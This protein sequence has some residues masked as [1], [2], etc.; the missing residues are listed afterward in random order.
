MRI[1]YFCCSNKFGGVENI[2]VQTL[3]ALSK[4]HEVAFIAPKNCSYKDKFNSR[5]KIFEYKNFDKRYNPFLYIYIARIVQG[6]GYDIVH[7]HGAKATQIF[8]ILNKFINKKF[9]ATK[10]NTRKGKI[11]NKVKNVIAVSKQT[12]KTIKNQ[13]SVL[14]FGIDKSEISPKILTSDFSIVAVGRLDP[15]KG[16]DELIK[17]VSRLKF[18]FKLFI[19]GDG[20]DRARLNSLISDLNLKDRV[21]ILGFRDDVK[22]ILSGCDLQ[23]ISSKSEGLPNVLFEGIFYANMLI[24]TDVGGISEILEPRFLFDYGDLADKITEIYNNKERYSLEFKSFCQI[25]QKELSFD[26][27]LK[28]LN[29]YYKGLK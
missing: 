16:F 21:E 20:A 14:Y 9:V 12:A 22:E 19:V 29:D 24:S 6:G 28:N 5:V 3:N 2:I 23:V 26:R 18:K 27:Y 10:H 8:Y 7:T 4:Q 11:F 1:C 13:S 25:K 15:I 17:A